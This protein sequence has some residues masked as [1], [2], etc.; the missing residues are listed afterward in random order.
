MQGGQLHSKINKR[1]GEFS[2][3][4][5]KQIMLGLAK[6]LKELHENG[7]MHRDIKAENIMLRDDNCLAPVI[8]DLG[9]SAFYDEPSYLL[10]RCGT[11]G[12]VAPEITKVTQG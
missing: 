3:G 2:M 1:N 12:Y 5:I 9:F 4:E 8:A 10:C 7:I 6:G 11:P